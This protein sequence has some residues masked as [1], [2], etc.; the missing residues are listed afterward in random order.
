MVAAGQETVPGE[1]RGVRV[2]QVLFTFLPAF[3]CLKYFSDNRY[4]M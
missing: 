1:A 4:M 2:G 3:W